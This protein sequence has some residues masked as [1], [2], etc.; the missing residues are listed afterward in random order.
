MFLF[1]LPPASFIFKH[2]FKE[3]PDPIAFFNL[4]SDH[5]IPGRLI[6]KADDPDL[7]ENRLDPQPC[8]AQNISCSGNPREKFYQNRRQGLCLIEINGQSLCPSC[9]RKT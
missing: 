5:V 8:L 9:Y 2:C 6:A 7:V 3:D 1:I 4:D